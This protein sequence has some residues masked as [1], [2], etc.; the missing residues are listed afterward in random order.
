MIG[1]SRVQTQPVSA[2]AGYQRCKKVQ[3]TANLCGTDHLLDQPLSVASLHQQMGHFCSGTPA[4]SGAV[5]GAFPGLH[6]P[7]ALPVLTE[8]KPFPS[9]DRLKKK[10]LTTIQL[11]LV[12][13][14][15]PCL[16]RAHPLSLL[17]HVGIKYFND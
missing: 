7:G 8:L 12:L 5:L 1:I 6:K 3:K 10:K 14:Y 11:P 2:G 16:L 15:S 4:V 17:Q 13:H 9:R